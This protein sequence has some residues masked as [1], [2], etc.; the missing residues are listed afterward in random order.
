MKAWA[1]L[2]AALLFLSIPVANLIVEGTI[3][4][5]NWAFRLVFSLFGGLIL[6]LVAWWSNEASYKNA[7]IDTYLNKESHIRTLKSTSNE[8]K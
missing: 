8:T 5:E 7:K 1:L 3:R 2:C 6:S 4:F